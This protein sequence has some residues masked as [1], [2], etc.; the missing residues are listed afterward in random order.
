MWAFTMEFKTRLPYAPQRMVCIK[1][2]IID[3]ETVTH[4]L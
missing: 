1:Q 2:A 4:L 3:L